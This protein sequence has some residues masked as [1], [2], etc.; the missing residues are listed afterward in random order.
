MNKFLE[1][2]GEVLST[3]NLE[4]IRNCPKKIQKKVMLT[5]QS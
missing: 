3:E 1:S 5:L 4:E 2:R